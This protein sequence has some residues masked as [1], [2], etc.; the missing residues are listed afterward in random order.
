MANISNNNDGFKSLIS[1]YGT[2]AAKHKTGLDK[3]H[4]KGKADPSGRKDVT[5]GLADK[6]VFLKLY[7]E[8]LKGQDPT[9]PQDTN[10]MVAQMSQFSS[11]E[12]LSNISDQLK[13]MTTSLTSNQALGASTLVGK[14]LMMKGD[15]A[16]VT[17]SQEDVALKT[18]VPKGAQSA[19]LKIYDAN[20][21]LVRTAKLEHDDYKWDKK[22]DKG[23]VLP[24]GE[25][26]FAASIV[27]DK[28]EVSALPTE[29]P[30]R[31]QGVTINGADGPV[32][33]VENHGK[34][35][36]TKELEILG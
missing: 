13:N 6:N 17:D 8:Q 4:A 12:K 2:D 30:S 19:T 23:N 18:I 29:L 20:N 34:V 33:N 27:N 31:I 35:K 26:R 16:M 10:D 28:G 9:A 1:Q 24:A 14:S 32:L 3:P 7:I 21:K 22:D 25:Y 5:G 15:K 36:L 11:L